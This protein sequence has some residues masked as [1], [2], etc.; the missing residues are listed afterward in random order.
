MGGGGVG[1]R[2]GR[3]ERWGGEVGGLWFGFRCCGSVRYRSGRFD[4]ILG[5]SIVE[6]AM[7]GAGGD[8]SG[9]CDGD[10]DDDDGYVAVGDR[11]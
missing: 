3:W 7:N 2:G 8:D 4:T 9:D 5:Q 6:T 11:Y 1:W 10:S